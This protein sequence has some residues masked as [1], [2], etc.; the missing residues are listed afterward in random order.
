ML[1]DNNSIY[2]SSKANP[3]SFSS[4]AIF[5]LV[6]LLSPLLKGLGREWSLNFT[7]VL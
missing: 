3:S 5:L 2:Y 6:Y 1:A 7:D 4:L